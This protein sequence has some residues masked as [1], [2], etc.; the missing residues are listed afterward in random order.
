[1]QDSLLI[2]GFDGNTDGQRGVQCR[3]Q[4]RDAV[5][6]LAFIQQRVAFTNATGTVEYASECAPIDTNGTAI[7]ERACVDQYEHDF[8]VGQSYL[9]TYTYYVGTRGEEI[10]VNDCQRSTTVSFAHEYEDTDCG[11]TNDDENLRT[12]FRRLT[13]IDTT[14]DG[15]IEIAPCAESG[16]T[17]SY[18]SLPN[19]SDAL[20]FDANL[21]T[22]GASST[23]AASGYIG[24]GVDWSD[25]LN[26]IALTTSNTNCHWQGNP[27]TVIGTQ[28]LTAQ[29][30]YDDDNTSQ[31][32]SALASGRE[33]LRGDGT[34]YQVLDERQWTLRLT[35]L[36]PTLVTQACTDKYAHNFAAAQSYLRTYTHY[37]N[38]G[39]QEVTVQACQPDV[40]VVFAHKYDNAQCGF[41]HN[42]VSLSS[43]PQ[44]STFIDTTD[45]GRIEIAPC[46]ES[47]QTIAYVYSR[48]FSESH[49]GSINSVN[50]SDPINTL[51]YTSGG[52]CIW[53]DQAT[54][55]IVTGRVNNP[56][57]SSV[58][59]IYSYCGSRYENKS[60]STTAVATG[61]LYQRGDSTEYKT[62][63]EIRWTKSVSA[64][65]R[66][67]R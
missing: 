29:C 13:F 4:H 2:L 34:K 66:Q 45:D 38:S 58:Q 57:S 61:L 59:N 46:A 36:E 63:Q 32:I 33:Y 65:A 8:T 7:I 11:I 25:P 14:D 44:Q 16:Q 18:A 54:Y 15:R 64:D 31:V 21:Q 35:G 53:R 37:T 27:T 6:N 20:S 41:T 9:R 48:S 42:D 19:F 1:M 28:D 62:V 5:N 60:S 51:Y 55:S 26:T 40:T 43:T 12:V 10:V 50:W 39:G 24:N 52:V 17:T 30:T 22:F 23:R 3:H 49:T 56:T 67:D 47:G